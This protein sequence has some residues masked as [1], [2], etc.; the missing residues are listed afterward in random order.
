MA[1]KRSAKGR[2]INT[3]DLVSNTKTVK[4]VSNVNIN[5]NGDY[6]DK[7]GN[8]IKSREDIISDYRKANANSSVKNVSI[9]TESKDAFI[10]KLKETE[11]KTAS[12]A[13]DE[14]KGRK[15]KLVKDDENGSE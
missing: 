12:D 3:D 1:I 2:M 7:A 11:F 9:K 14:L 13:V 10:N 15:R 6:L 4:A 5:S 8:I